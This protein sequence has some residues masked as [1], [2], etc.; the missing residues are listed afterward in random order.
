MRP[1]QL[2]PSKSH[3]TAPTPFLLAFPPEAG[4][5]APTRTTLVPPISPL[6]CGEQPCRSLRASTGRQFVVPQDV[7]QKRRARSLVDTAPTRGWLCIGSS[8]LPLLQEKY[9]HPAVL[10]APGFAEMSSS[11]LTHPCA[12]SLGEPTRIFARLFAQGRPCCQVALAVVHTLLKPPGRY[13][14]WSV[15]LCFTVRSQLSCLSFPRWLCGLG[16][17]DFCRW[18]EC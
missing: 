15:R 5:P 16:G 7:L 1:C 17:C 10:I 14:S 11:N 8:A 13:D 2:A 6:L 4:S 9:P 3:A 18:S 12:S